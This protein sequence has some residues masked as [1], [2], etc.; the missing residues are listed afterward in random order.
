MNASETRIL[1][2][3]LPARL[4][5]WPKIEMKVVRYQAFRLFNIVQAR[6]TAPIKKQEKPFPSR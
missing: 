3:T 5:L 1:L 4:G 6:E 2:P